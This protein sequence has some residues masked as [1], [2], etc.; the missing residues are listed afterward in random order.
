MHSNVCFLNKRRRNV[1]K[2]N[3][4]A[5]SKNSVSLNHSEVAMHN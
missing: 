1:M 4:P 2:M 5:K 3:D